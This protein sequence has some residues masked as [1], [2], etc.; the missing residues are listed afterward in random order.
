MYHIPTIS[1]AK[2]QHSQHSQARV[3]CAPRAP[4]PSAKIWRLRSCTLPDWCSFRELWAF[5]GSMGDPKKWVGTFVAYFWSYFLGIFPYISLKNRPEIYGSRY[6]YFRFLLHG[7]IRNIAQGYQP[8]PARVSR[9]P[10]L[11]F[12]FRAETSCLAQSNVPGWH[13]PWSYYLL[14]NQ[15]VLAITKSIKK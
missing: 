7:V 9:T 5:V 14:R 11:L 4:K 2:Q 12:K 10:L 6:L 13:Q 15:E 1:R 8:R 3:R